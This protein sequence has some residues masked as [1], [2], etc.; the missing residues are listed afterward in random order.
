MRD[1]ITAVAAAGQERGK[2]NE[3]REDEKRAETVHQGVP[4]GEA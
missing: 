2:S 3:S 4:S 1:E